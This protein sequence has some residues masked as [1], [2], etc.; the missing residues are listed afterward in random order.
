LRGADL[1][2]ADLLGA[3]LITAD[4]RDANLANADVRS[5]NL[6]DAD[7]RD[8]DRGEAA[9]SENVRSQR[10]IS[11]ERTRWLA[12]PRRQ[13]A[14]TE[15][16]FPRHA[17]AAGA[18]PTAACAANEGRLDAGAAATPASRGAQPSAAISSAEK[19]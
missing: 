17:G 5:A 3:D 7:L 18:P 13:G 12:E 14:G 9:R 15:N 11:D 19:P 6:H 2:G 4:L 10:T 1:R 8:T 16:E